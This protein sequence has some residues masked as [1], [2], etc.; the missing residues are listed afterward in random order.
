ML[1]PNSLNST[2]KDWN[3]IYEKDLSDK[4]IGCCFE[5]RKHLK[6]GLLEKVYENSLIQEFKLRNIKVKSQV[7][8]EVEYKG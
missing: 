6:A 2:D 1:P 7:P 4:I 3:M 5:V 8:L